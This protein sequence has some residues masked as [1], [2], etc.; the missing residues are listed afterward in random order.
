MKKLN[1]VFDMLYLA[2]NRLEDI[3]ARLFVQERYLKLPN[4][5]NIWL[6]HTREEISKK[7]DELTHDRNW[8]LL[9]LIEINKELN[10]VLINLI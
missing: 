9:K 6:F 7:I 2:K 8:Y 4:D 1:P 3:D 10:T 5:A